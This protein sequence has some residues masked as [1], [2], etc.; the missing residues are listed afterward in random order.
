MQDNGAVLVTFSRSVWMGFASGKSL[1]AE[2]Y[3][4]VV[5]IDITVI[6]ITMYVQTFGGMEVVHT[7]TSFSL[8]SP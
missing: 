2:Q 1:A 3:R 6:I 5:S 8:S 7:S 4:D